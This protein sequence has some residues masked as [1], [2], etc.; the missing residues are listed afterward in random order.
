M[1]RTRGGHPYG[2]FGP[3][4]PPPAPSLGDI[5]F[6][7]LARATLPLGDIAKQMKTRTEMGSCFHARILTPFLFKQAQLPAAEKQESS[8]WHA[9]HLDCRQAAAGAAAQEYRLGSMPGLLQQPQQ[10]QPAQQPQETRAVPRVSPRTA[11]RGLCGAR[12]SS[13]HWFPAAQR[14]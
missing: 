13:S 8:S 10:Q 5:L 12:G 11:A 7:P 14:Q 2:P 6:W 9:A 1:G 3:I 4:V